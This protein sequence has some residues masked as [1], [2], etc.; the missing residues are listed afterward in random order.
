MIHLLLGRPIC[1]ILGGHDW[2]KRGTPVVET[3][4]VARGSTEAD[5][6]WDRIRRMDIHQVDVPARAQEPC[7]VSVGVA[8]DEPFAVGETQWF[9]LSEE[10]P[11]V[12]V[13]PSGL[14]KCTITAAAGSDITVGDLVTFTGEVP[15][16]AC[17]RC[18]FREG[19]DQ[20]EA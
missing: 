7:P 19:P 5:A 14:R 16:F 11:H 4:P 3:V 20:W 18:G 1:W 17:R 13:H 6:A 9:D 15:Y 12:E 2:E 8:T 10:G